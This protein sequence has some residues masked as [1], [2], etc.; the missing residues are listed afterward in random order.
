MLR[1]ILQLYKR[2]TEE[3]SGYHQMQAIWFGYQSD[4]ICCYRAS[5]PNTVV[6][7]LRIG[8][9]SL[10]KSSI[11]EA[12]CALRVSMVML[13]IKQSPTLCLSCM[14][15]LYFLIQANSHAWAVCQ[16]HIP[17]ASERRKKKNQNNKTNQIFSVNEKEKNL[18]LF[19]QFEKK[20][21]NY[22]A[23]GSLVNFK[24]HVFLLIFIFSY[25]TYW[26]ILLWFF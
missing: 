5:T 4:Y 24:M 15:W 3:P 25:C 12:N 7:P 6:L 2:R 13:F 1:S 8:D 16:A 17:Y 21:I 10:K 22:N 20:P 23:G 11:Y 18:P 26:K 14:K 9:I 19:Y